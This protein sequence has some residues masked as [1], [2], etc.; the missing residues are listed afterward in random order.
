MFFSG[1]MD[2]RLMGVKK[3]LPQRSPSRLIFFGAYNIFLLLK[4]LF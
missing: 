4:I 2:E 1:N 3:L